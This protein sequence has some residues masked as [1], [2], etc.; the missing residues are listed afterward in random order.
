MPLAAVDAKT[1]IL[2][3]RKTCCVVTYTLARVKCMIFNIV[4]SIKYHMSNLYELFRR[5]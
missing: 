3:G 5:V 1:I 4:I 2:G